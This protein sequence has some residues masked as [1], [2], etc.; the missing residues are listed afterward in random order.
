MNY[1]DAQ[2][3]KCLPFPLDERNSADD[4]NGQIKLKIH[5]IRGET[6][7]LNVSPEQMREIETILNQ[8]VSA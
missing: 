6:N 4:R 7:W 8:E 2:L 5:T 3:F 1:I